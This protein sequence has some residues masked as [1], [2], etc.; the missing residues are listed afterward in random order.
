[1]ANGNGNVSTL[2]S[3]TPKV[4]VGGADAPGLASHFAQMR[5]VEQA[6]GLFRCEASFGNWGATGGGIGF[7]FFKR[8]LLE[9]GKQFVIKLGEDTVFDGKIM[10]LEGNFLE[11]QP[12]QITVLAEDRM[13]D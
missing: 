8:D 9:F 12:P 4:A 6:S 2:R 5:I 3:G 1:M 7:L 10:A 11:G 13:Q